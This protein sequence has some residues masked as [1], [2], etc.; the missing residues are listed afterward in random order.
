MPG[1]TVFAFFGGACELQGVIPFG[2][3][4]SELS[5]C[6]LPLAKVRNLV[7]NRELRGLS[8]T[9]ALFLADELWQGLDDY[10]RLSSIL[11]AASLPFKLATLGLRI[12]PLSS[13]MLT[14]E[15]YL[16][17]YEPHRFRLTV[18]EH[19]RWCAS[20]VSLGYAQPSINR[21][22][23]DGT[24]D[25]RSQE[26]RLHPHLTDIDGLSRFE[27]LV[28]ERDGE[29]KGTDLLALDSH[30]CDYACEM[31]KLVGLGIYRDKEK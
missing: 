12:A 20:L 9:D 27:S 29:H 7:Y 26:D 2:C 31:L 19:Y 18:L 4:T 14:Q 30:L 1:T 21:V 25:G 6:L 5:S 3:G 10:G 24:G 23:S 16:S 15:D 22:L 28:A 11:S 17:I 8:D 13:D